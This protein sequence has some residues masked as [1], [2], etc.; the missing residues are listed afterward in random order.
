MLKL[1]GKGAD[2][3]QDDGGGDLNSRL[4]LRPAAAG[5]YRRIAFT[6][7]GGQKGAFD[8]MIRLTTNASNGS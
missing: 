6:F 1:L 4:V 2:L 8:L 7:P 3:A 5:T